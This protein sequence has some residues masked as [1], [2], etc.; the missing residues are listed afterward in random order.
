MLVWE[1][2]EYGLIAWKQENE[3]GRHTELGF[4]NPDFVL[5]A[6]SFGWE[7]VRVE[8]SRE[9]ASALERAFAADRP[10]LVVVPIDYRENGLLSERLGALAC[11][12]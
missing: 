1:D 12:I 5:L 11:P 9:L 3:F 10:A 2:H 6:E 7:G 4:G 8:R